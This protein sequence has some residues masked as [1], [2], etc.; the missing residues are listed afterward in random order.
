M[1]DEAN[2]PFQSA[3]SRAPPPPPPEG[4]RRTL[5]PEETDLLLMHEANWKIWEEAKNR[6]DSKTFKKATQKGKVFHRQL[7]KLMGFQYLMDRTNQWNP[8]LWDW[9][10]F[11]KKARGRKDTA[12]TPYPRKNQAQYPQHDQG[13]RESSAELE[14]TV[15][16]L[17]R[18]LIN[19]VFHHLKLYLDPLFQQVEN[20]T[21]EIQ[22]IK[23]LVH[24]NEVPKKLEVVDK[25][26]Q[27]L[28]KNIND[29]VRTLNQ[30]GS[31]VKKCGDYM[32][33]VQSDLG[34]WSRQALETVD[35]GL[36]T[37]R[38]QI[39]ESNKNGLIEQTKLTNSILQSVKD[40]TLAKNPAGEAIQSKSSED[41]YMKKASDQISNL[42]GVMRQ[43]Q[44]SMLHHNEELTLLKSHNDE[45]I[46]LLSDFTL[47][48][49]KNNESK[50]KTTTLA[51]PEFKH[52]IPPHMVN[53]KREA[54]VRSID[55]RA[56]PEPLGI[57]Q[58]QNSDAAENFDMKVYD[59]E[60]E[61]HTPYDQKMNK[62]KG[63]DTSTRMEVTQKKRLEAAQPS[64]TRQDVIDKVLEQCTGDLDHA[65]RS[66]MSGDEDFVSF[67]TTFEEVVKRTSIGRQRLMNKNAQDWK[68]QATSGSNQQ[69]KPV[70]AK[71]PAIRVPGKCDTCGSTEAGH[72]YRACRRKNKV[73][74]NVEIDPLEED[75]LTG[76]EIEV[77][78]GDDHDSFYDDG[79][80]R[81]VQEE[82]FTIL[83]I[84]CLETTPQIAPKFV[85]RRT[86]DLHLGSPFMT[87]MCN[88]WKLS[89][90]ID[91]GACSSLISPR[92][93][94]IVWKT[95]KEDMRPHQ[96]Q[97]YLSASGNLTAIGEIT[98]PITFL[99]AMPQQ[100]R[101]S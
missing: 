12:S 7:S 25:T 69:S 82:S 2:H 73:I 1:I 81:A 51:P 100:S 79:E 43:L 70:V 67:T 9:N 90:L 8:A 14:K 23:S 65:V 74:N 41:Y 16:P 37:T 52:E 54:S 76:E 33:L 39:V 63:R 88:G 4:P 71:T 44:A 31:V 95:W 26:L 47:D 36:S 49:L 75:S 22:T 19:P 46:K 60:E 92:I 5:T 48:R 93:L 98:I 80:Y 18:E 50:E 42:Q 34:K 99:H 64:T 91:T 83:D 58:K 101:S 45:I 27:H 96:N 28:V 84:S 57:Q 38:N 30:V 21:H 97:R 66:R 53:S 78:F 59:K 32:I 29:Q 35:K 56:P 3:G 40:I 87:T 15:L 77:L 13:S 10:T 86:V 6:Q 94:D 24:T 72:D 20:L 89:I 17:D 68:T 85:E 11:E 62:G 55:H 61:I